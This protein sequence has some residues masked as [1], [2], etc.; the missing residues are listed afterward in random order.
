LLTDMGYALELDHCIRCEKACPEG[1]PAFVDAGGGGIIC[2][3]CGGARRTIGGDVRVLA[4]R[5]QRSE[6]V[7]LHREHASAIVELLEE[8]MIAHR[9]YERRR[10]VFLA[11]QVVT[12]QG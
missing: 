9:D 1:R 5:A 2:T 10:N 6:R 11:D 8:A 7:A 12:R 3:S 4:A